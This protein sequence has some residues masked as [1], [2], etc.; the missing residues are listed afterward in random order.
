MVHTPLAPHYSFLRAI[1]L[2]FLKAQT[3][4][5]SW[6]FLTPHCSPTTRNPNHVLS[7]AVKLL[8]HLEAPSTQPLGQHLNF[9]R[10]TQSLDV[11]YLSGRGTLRKEHGLCFGVAQFSTG[12]RNINS[13]VYIRTKWLQRY[14]I[15]ETWAICCENKHFLL[16][17]RKKISLHWSD[18]QL[19]T[20]GLGEH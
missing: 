11:C 18:S 10:S 1:K 15:L 7:V 16:G 2:T 9:I 8:Y 20:E 19:D 3:Q 17:E 5:D 12:N 14:C 6:P 4:G 13:C